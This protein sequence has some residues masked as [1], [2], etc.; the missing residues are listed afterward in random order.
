VLRCDGPGSYGWRVDERFLPWERHDKEPQGTGI[1]LSGGG[2]R[3]ASFSFGAVQA[4]QD[5][6]GLIFGPDCADCLAVVSGG[7]YL[8][9]ALMLN[10]AHLSGQ[11]YGDAPPLAQG[12]P[13]AKHV[14]SHGSYLKS[15]GTTAKMLL[16][17]LLNVLA[18]VALFVWAAVMLSAAVA[19][20]GAIGV[21]SSQTVASQVVL[22]VGFLFGA[23]LA[24]R[25]L[26]IDGGGRRIVLP[27]VGGL[28]MIATAPSTLAAIRHVDALSD[29]FWWTHN[30]WRAPLALVVC[31]FLIAVSVG[32]ARV[33]RRALPTRFAAWLVARLPAIVGGVLFCLTATAFAPRLERGSASNATNR[34]ALIAG[35]ILF[36]GLL[37][38]YIMQLLARTS[39]HAL[40]RDSLATCFSVRRGD[41]LVELVGSTAQKLS[42][43]KPPEPGQAGSFPRLLVCATANVVWNPRQPAERPVFRLP[44][45]PTRR[46]APFV[47]SH[48][49]C[50]VP[51]VPYASVATTD[52]EKLKTRSA[53]LGSKEPVVSLMSAVASTGAAISPA[54]GRKTSDVARPI[55]AL[56]NLRLGRWVPN[57]MSARIRAELG[58][59]EA[60]KK[61]RRRHGVGGAYDEFVP[62]L[63]GLHHS[64]AARVYVSDGGHYDNLGLLALLHARCREIWCLDAQADADGSAG[65]LRHV[66]KLAK[67]ELDINIDIDTSVF[68]ASEPGVLSVGHANGTIHYPGTT[69]GRLV[70]I[71]LGLVADEDSDD[72]LAYRSSDPGFAHHSTFWPPLRVMWY[73]RERFDKYRAVGYANARAASLSDAKPEPN[74]R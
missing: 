38:A 61:M 63:F 68:A 43:L 39:L 58:T 13:E 70:V 5:H 25:G 72:L 10:A 28:I 6:R 32:L 14:V 59:E 21:E 27:L 57:P 52:L 47:Y 7:S 56:M 54:M 69:T 48:D 1:C 51:G 16:A 8:A 71:K 44:W 65:Q 67:E 35:V 50:G 53:P 2:L 12:S 45:T 49:R 55:I 23:R 46:F 40:Y 41:G 30:W 36:G 73:G 11:A 42:E 24:L 26:Y 66:L 19:L 37:G 62:E 18:F 4:L 3:A 20:A 64:D 33:W 15:W 22:A 31:A 74:A 9:A 17:G 60:D 34:E 29:T